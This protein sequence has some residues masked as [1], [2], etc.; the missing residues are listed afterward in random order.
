MNNEIEYTVDLGKIWSV[1]R[2]NIRMFVLILLVCG[3]AAFA[4]TKLL[5][6][7][8]YSATSSVVIVSNDTAGEQS[9]TYT[10]VQLSQ[11]L[12]STYSRILMSETVGDKV[13]KNLALD[14]EGY[15]ADDYKDIV[16]VRS[17]DNTE[18]LDVVATTGDPMLSARISNEAVKVFSDQVYDIM[19]IRN[20]T[21]LDTAKVPTTPS[22][23]N[24]KRNTLLGLLAGFLICA[25]I[26]IVKMLS[27]TT[28]K[29]ED[30]VKRLLDYPII[31]SIPEV[32]GDSNG[33]ETYG[34]KKESV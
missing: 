9:I 14:K 4:G 7:K 19:N 26:T 13:I 30:E 1:I 16:K 11:K 34:S 28:I 15:T 22:G 21:V 10:D 29:T 6:P 5:I 27:D 18:V 32:D 8:E 20:V 23:P 33:G 12:V 31:G 17:S 25:V 2:E 24:V 3:L